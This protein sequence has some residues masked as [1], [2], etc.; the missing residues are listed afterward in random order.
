MPNINEFF[1]KPELLHK[2][3][4]EKIEGLKPCSQC[5]ENAQEAYWDPFT[6]ILSWECKNGHKSQ[7]KV[8]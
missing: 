6:T 7:F 1:H 3:E 5:D 4:L 8:N 2:A